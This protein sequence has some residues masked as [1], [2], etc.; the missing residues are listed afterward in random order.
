MASVRRFA[1]GLGVV[2]ALL[3]SG[4][5]LAQQGVTATPLPIEPRGTL[6]MLDVRSWSAGSA[7][8]GSQWMSIRPGPDALKREACGSA[9]LWA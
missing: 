1:F 5:A 9:L 2:V 4:P 3:A 8:P 7:L 6:S